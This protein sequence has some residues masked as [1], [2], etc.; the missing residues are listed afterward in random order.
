QLALGGLLILY[1]AS[2][3]FLA[4]R[5]TAISPAII[6]PD[7]ADALKQLGIDVGPLLKLIMSLVYG[8]LIV[9][10]IFAQGGLALYYH[11]R[12]KYVEAYIAKTPAW[13][14]RLQQAGF[15]A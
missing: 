13:I 9:V 2:Q 14:I 4:M 6:T 15:S 7:S 11:L 1:A 10:A 5:R 3:I 8:G 12:G